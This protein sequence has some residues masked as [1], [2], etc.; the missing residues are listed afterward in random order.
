MRFVGGFK[1]TDLYTKAFLATDIFLSI[2]FEVGVTLNCKNLIYF[3]AIQQWFLFM[4][5]IKNWTSFYKN[6]YQ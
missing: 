3:R 1:N 5:G 4:A 6:F 2:F